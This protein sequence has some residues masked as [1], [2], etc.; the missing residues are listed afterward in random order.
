[1]RHNYDVV[2]L[3][4]DKYIHTHKQDWYTLQVLLEDELVLDA[5][6]R[7]QLKVTKKSWSDP[8]FDWSTTRSVLFRTT[9]DYFDRFEEFSPWLQNIEKLTHCINPAKV[10]RWNLDKR[11]LIELQN[12]QINCVETHHLPR[13]SVINLTAL[14]EQNNWTEAIIKPVVSGAARHTYRVNQQN[15]EQLNSLINELLQHEDF[16]IQ[17]FQKAILEQGEISLMVM[18]GQFTHAVRKIAAPGDFR[19]QDD[20]GGTV[21]PYIPTPEEIEFAERAIASCTPRPLYG[22]VDL[23][24]D[25]NHQLAI[26]ELELIEPELFFRFCRPAAKVLANGI[27]SYLDHF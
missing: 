8:S 17:P 19:V 2:L 26:M 22:R 6:R 24:R 16:L 21:Q 11:Y 20:H 7:V 14:L 5:L 10:I 9:W 4:E 25:N 3:T 13:N 23:I 12:K 1:M 15:S 27:K 18:N